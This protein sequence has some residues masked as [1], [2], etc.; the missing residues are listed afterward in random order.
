MERSYTHFG[1]VP[2]VFSTGIWAE[3]DFAARCAIREVYRLARRGSRDRRQARNTAKD[4]AIAIDFHRRW[5]RR[6]A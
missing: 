3:P 1:G 2:V 5:V 6:S 4:A